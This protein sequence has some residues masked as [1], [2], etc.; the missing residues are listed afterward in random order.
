MTKSSV[1]LLGFVFLLLNAGGNANGATWCVAKPSASECVLQLNIEYA[2]NML[3][4]CKMIQS[5]GACFYPDT[6][7]NHAS[8]IMNHYYATNG[9]NLWNCNFSDSALIAV[10]DPS[11]GSCNY[12]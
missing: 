3:P 12:V 8:A 2:C 7:M 6:P 11:Y 1:S 5:C 9:R 10:T 4:S